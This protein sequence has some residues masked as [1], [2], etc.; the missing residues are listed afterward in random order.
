MA[1]VYVIL[2]VVGRPYI[3]KNM[4]FRNMIVDDDLRYETE[5]KIV[6][7]YVVWVNKKSV[8]DCNT[9]IHPM[10]VNREPRWDM[11]NKII[12]GNKSYTFLANE[13]GIREECANLAMIKY[14]FQSGKMLPWFGIVGIKIKEAHLKMIDTEG[15]LP[16]KNFLEDEV[17]EDESEDESEEEEDAPTNFKY[18]NRCH[19][20]W[21]MEKQKHEWKQYLGAGHYCSPEIIE[22]E[23]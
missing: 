20:Q 13:N 10:F 18:P 3:A 19:K 6:G 22:D 15:V 7:G 1:T 8:N 4:I 16:Y 17:S 2:P 11:A 21:N 12:Q 5:R 9:M 14:D 23:E